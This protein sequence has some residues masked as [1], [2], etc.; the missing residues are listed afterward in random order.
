MSSY[1]KLTFGCSSHSNALTNNPKYIEP[2]NE[3]YFESTPP[4]MVYPGGMYPKKVVQTPKFQKAWVSN[5]ECPSCNNSVL[6]SRPLL[7]HMIKNN[8]GILKKQI[9]SSLDAIGTDN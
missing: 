8:T 4:M 3:V 9:V 5:N 6:S 2:F 7:K 1:A